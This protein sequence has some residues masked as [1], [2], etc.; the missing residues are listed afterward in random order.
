MGNG[1]S[2]VHGELGGDEAPIRTEGQP[3]MEVAQLL[4]GAPVGPQTRLATRWHPPLEDGVEVERPRVARLPQPEGA[5]PEGR[6]D[7]S[8]RVGAHVHGLDQRSGRLEGPSAVWSRWSFTP[9]AALKITRAGRRACRSRLSGRSRGGCRVRR[10]PSRR[11]DQRDGRGDEHGPLAVLTHTGSPCDLWTRLRPRQ[12]T[13]SPIWGRVR[14]EGRRFATGSGCRWVGSDGACVLVLSR[15]PPR[16]RRRSRP[17]T[18]CPG[19]RCPG[20][21]G[22]WVPGAGT[23]EAPPRG[24]FGC[25]ADA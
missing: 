25:L 24:Y 15:G 23:C 19:S 6:I 13:L 17:R 14:G 2:G 9:T 22:A 11:E 3:G 7:R 8:R 21:S 12:P 18:A 5:G 4:V 1:R 20:T 10:A 16:A